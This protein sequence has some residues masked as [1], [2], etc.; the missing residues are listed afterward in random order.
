MKD[1]T[2]ELNELIEIALDKINEL[3]DKDNMFRVIQY[4]LRQLNSNELILIIN[5]LF[6]ILKERGIVIDEIMYK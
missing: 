2:K 1:N 6:D 4:R 5:Y 3:K